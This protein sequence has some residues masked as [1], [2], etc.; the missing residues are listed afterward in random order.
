MTKL[1]NNQKKFLRAIGHTLKPVVRVGQQGL[2]AS[3]LA[4][5]ESSMHTH[6]LLKIKIRTDKREQ[7][8]Q[9]IGQIIS[10]LN[11]HLVQVIGNIVV[12]YRAFDEAP[13]L[14]L[15]RK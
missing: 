8:Q 7:K 14:V 6:E 15:P 10:E 9:I 1:T 5:L 2:S 12:I 11:A 13:K 3:V 4:E